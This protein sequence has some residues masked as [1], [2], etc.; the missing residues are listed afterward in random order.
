MASPTF[1]FTPVNYAVKAGNGLGPKTTIVSLTISGGISQ[2]NLNEAVR[3]IQL[4]GTHGGVANDAYTVAGVSAF[5]AAST[6]T[7]YLALQGT[8]TFTA[9]GSDALGITGLVTAVVTTFDQNPA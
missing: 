5:T 2:A 7:V 6:E 8:G 1:D 3:L 4:G 9:D